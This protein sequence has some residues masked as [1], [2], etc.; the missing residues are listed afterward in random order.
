MV[1]HRMSRTLAWF[2]FENADFIQARAGQAAVSS[3]SQRTRLL[4]AQRPR[5]ACGWR[6]RPDSR[7]R[8]EPGN[9]VLPA[10]RMMTTGAISPHR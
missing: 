5:M 9:Q 10:Q 6:S 3:G 2:P 1:E 8:D 7:R 4:S